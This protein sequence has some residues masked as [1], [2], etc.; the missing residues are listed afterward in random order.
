MLC[1]ANKASCYESDSLVLVRKS[2]VASL[3]QGK[4]VQYRIKLLLR[5]KR[6]HPILT[7]HLNQFFLVIGKPYLNCPADIQV[8]LGETMSSIQLGY[9]FP[10][11]QT[12]MQITSVSHPRDHGFK[13]GNTVV[14]FEAVNE[15]GVRKSCQ[16]LVAVLGEC[17]LI[18]Y[19]QY[20]IILYSIA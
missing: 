2:E 14:K 11:P 20:Y 7:H 16:V 5:P 9:R 3:L 4:T 13:V 17:C 8:T 6:T 12:N 1:E 18:I 15:E 19:C 10:E